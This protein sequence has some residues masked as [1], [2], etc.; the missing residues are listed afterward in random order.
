MNDNKV[1]KLT[2]REDGGIKR[3]PFNGGLTAGYLN[4]DAKHLPVTGDKAPW[5]NPQNYL[6]D[7]LQ[8]SFKS[9][10]P[11]S[12]ELVKEDVEVKKVR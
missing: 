12:M 11:D 6:Y 9:F 10:S 4:R 8:L 5:V 7:F 3:T 1:V 2:P